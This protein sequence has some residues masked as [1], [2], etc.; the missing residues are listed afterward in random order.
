MKTYFDAAM[1]ASSG[2]KRLKSYSNKNQT[3][4]VGLFSKVSDPDIVVVY[5]PGGVKPL[6]LDATKGPL[7]KSSP[8]KLR[9]GNRLSYLDSRLRGNDVTSLNNQSSPNLT[10]LQPGGFTWR[11]LPLWLNRGVAV[12][13]VDFPAK[14]KKEMPPTERVK[15]ERIDALNEIIN[16]IRSLFPRAIVA[17]YGHSYGAL[18]MSLLARTKLLDKA[19]IG[20]G[21]WNQS[22]DKKDPYAKVHVKG[23]DD[24]TAAIPTLIVHHEQDKTSK[25]QIGEAAKIMKMFDSITVSGGIPHL[26]APGTDPGPHF[27]HMQEDEVVRNILLWVRNKQ[28]C[29][30]IE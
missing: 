3:T 30:F 6:G 25:C 26:G 27:F 23:F 18:E 2:F 4:V 15:K 16:D 24:T 9:S 11:W 22:P 8:R 12:A 14:F 28:Y 1:E 17:G 13:T 5:I 10:T 19:I 7:K 29:H 20:S 21:S